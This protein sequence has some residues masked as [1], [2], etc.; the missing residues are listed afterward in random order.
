[1]AVTKAPLFS[2]ITISYNDLAGLRR[3]V[4]SIDAQVE[5]DLEHIIVDGG[6]TDGTLEYLQA[7]PEVPWR[8]WSSEADS[9]IYDAMNKGI[10]RSQGQLVMM[11][12]AGDYLAGPNSLSQI[13]RSYAEEGWQWAYGAVRFVRPDGSHAGSYTFDPF[14]SFRFRMGLLWIPHASVAMTRELLDRVGPY[15]IDYGTGADQELLMRALRVGEPT[16]IPEFLCHFER[17]GVSQQ[18]SSRKRELDWHRMRRDNS[19][20]LGPV[21]ADRLVS[22][23]L[24]L[25]APARRISRRLTGS[26]GMYAE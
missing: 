1:M 8:Q 10:A 19:M 7:L 25:R 20:T 4:E 23:L 5:G 17:G 21:Y 24:A 22:E 13:A 15:R 6:S 11:L 26:S 14:H 16:V 9:G 2:L 12:N 3:V 18:Q